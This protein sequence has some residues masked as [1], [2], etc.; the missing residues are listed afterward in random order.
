[1]QG[2]AAKAEVLTYFRS[3]ADRSSLPLILTNVSLPDV[4]TELAAHPNIIGVVDSSGTAASI[5]HI[6]AATAEIRHEVTVTTIF[7]AVTRR[8][9]QLRDNA[10]GSTYISADSLT[11][12]GTALAVAPP[13]SAIKTRTKT[14]GFQVIA[15]TTAGMLDSLG[16]GA[17]AC[18]TALSACAPQAVYE[19]YAAW[20]DGD[21]ALAQEK[22][23][24]VLQATQKIEQAMGIAG[25]RY[26][27]DLN[28]YFGGRPRLP[29]L[30]V[31]G[32]QRSAIDKLMQGIRN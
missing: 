1:M 27:C 3:V 18:M 7:A 8:M 19:V 32:E 22:Q 11:G 13:K 20:K 4:V 17:S 5:T 12:V 26:A 24:R 2:V 25:I 15:G 31:T 21:A 30:P 6:K 9:L 16:A 14:V 28:G 23:S 29:L 10:Q